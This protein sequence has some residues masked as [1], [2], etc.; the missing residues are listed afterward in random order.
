LKAHLLHSALSKSRGFF[1]RLDNTDPPDI[2]A[3]HNHIS[4]LLEKTKTEFK[5][6]AIHTQDE[7]TK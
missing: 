1:T 5:N 2:T 3:L 7:P 6:N 4:I